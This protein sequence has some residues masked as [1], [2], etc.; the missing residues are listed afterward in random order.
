MRERS[1]NTSPV[2]S[3]A[4]AI[5]KAAYDA[6]LERTTPEYLYDKNGA[7]VFNCANTATAHF[8][9]PDINDPKQYRVT[10]NWSLY[11]HPDK[12]GFEIID[13][14]DARPGDLVQW[15]SKNSKKPYPE[16]LGMFER[17]DNEG[18]IYAN[19]SDGTWKYKKNA[20]YG[21]NPSR[22]YR[23]IGMPKDWERWNDQDAQK[24]GYKNDA[25]MLEQL[26]KSIINL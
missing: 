20:Y 15:D 23:F 4:E 9:N 26:S 24:N 8:V 3:Q 18:K 2:H 11:K 19:Y 5:A 7:P 25:D 12:F 22:A 6:S 1:V 14:A 16:H 21:Y 10:G 13:I 17:V